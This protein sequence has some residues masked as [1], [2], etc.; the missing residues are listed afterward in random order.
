MPPTLLENVNR[1][2]MKPPS[3]S[4]TIPTAK[5]P[6]PPISYNLGRPHLKLFTLFFSP[7]EI[8]IRR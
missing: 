3:S 5:N 2:L 8:M 6:S 7:V 1:F 4:R